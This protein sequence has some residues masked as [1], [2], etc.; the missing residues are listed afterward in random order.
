M[1][2]RGDKPA[3]E[4]LAQFEGPIELFEPV[5]KAKDLLKF[6]KTLNAVS[7]QEPLYDYD[8][9]RLEDAG[10]QGPWHF[11]L[12]QSVISGLPGL[13]IPVILHWAKL[14]T[15]EQTPTDTAT[16]ALQSF[17]L[18]FSLM[19]TAYAVGRAS[20]WK[21]DSTKAARERAARIFLYLDGAYGLVPQLL[22]STAL[23]VFFL[24]PDVTYL[25][26]IIIWV[27]FSQL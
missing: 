4:H 27:G 18:P 1:P 26:Y 22:A 13:M 16:E 17:A 21:A 24:F 7:R 5:G 3:R 15:A 2:Q 19:L 25:E 20:L 12:T 11:N 8:K 9:R 10:Y 23:S 14:S 6:W